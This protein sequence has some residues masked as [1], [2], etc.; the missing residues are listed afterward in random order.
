MG[1]IPKEDR[2]VTIEDSQELFIENENRTQIAIPKEEGSKVAKF[3]NAIGK[4][5]VAV[6][7]ETKDLII[8]KGQDHELDLAK[9]SDDL[10]KALDNIVKHIH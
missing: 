8:G 1:E 7:K 2:V 4:G 10:N 3:A 9:E 5:A 6:A